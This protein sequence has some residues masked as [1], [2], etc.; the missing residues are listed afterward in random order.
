MIRWGKADGLEV[1]PELN[2]AFQTLE[3]AADGHSYEMI[4]VP[5]VHG[6]NSRAFQL[7]DIC[8]LFLRKKWN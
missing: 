6:L 7:R 3:I 2:H 4:D 1:I 5:D 8:S